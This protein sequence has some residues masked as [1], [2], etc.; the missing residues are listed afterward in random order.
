MLRSHEAGLLIGGYE[1]NEQQPYP[2]AAM[3]FDDEPSAAQARDWLAAK[4]TPALQLHIRS[5]PAGELSVELVEKQE[6]LW[7]GEIW[8]DETW[9]FFQA[10][11]EQVD[12]VLLMISVAG[13]VQPEPIHRL[14]KEQVTIKVQSD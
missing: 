11:Y 8:K 13:V 9:Q 6:T 5:T 3:D 14:G 10:F 2:F 1:E 4:N 12:H 7:S